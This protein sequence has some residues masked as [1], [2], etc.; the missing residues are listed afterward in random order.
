[1]LNRDHIRALLLHGSDIPSFSLTKQLSR[2]T[3]DVSSALLHDTLDL[4]ICQHCNN[5]APSNNSAPND[6]AYF[7]RYHIIYVIGSLSVFS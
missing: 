3:R 2:V 1:M 4:A 5:S 6:T 7:H